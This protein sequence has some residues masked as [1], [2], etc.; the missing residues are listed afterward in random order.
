M[1]FTLGRIGLEVTSEWIMW[2]IAIIVITGFIVYLG[3]KKI[4]IS[5]LGEMKKK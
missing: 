2:S 4:I 3:I 1:E 5:E